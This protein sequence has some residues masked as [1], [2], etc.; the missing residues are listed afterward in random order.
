MLFFFFFFLLFT[1][2]GTAGAF[3]YFPTLANKLAGS[4]SL[5]T[6]PWT[7]PHLQLAYSYQ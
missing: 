1:F 7:I 2:L 4:E 5:F 3:L 6:W